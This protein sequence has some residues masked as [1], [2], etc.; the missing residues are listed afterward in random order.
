MS[1]RARSASFRTLRARSASFPSSSHARIA[2]IPSSSRTTRARF[3]QSAPVCVRDPLA[4]NR[5]RGDSSSPRGGMT[6]GEGDVNKGEAP[7]L[8]EL[9]R[10][11]RLKELLKYSHSFRLPPLRQTPPSTREALSPRGS[12][13]MTHRAQPATRCTNFSHTSCAFVRRLRGRGVDFFPTA[14]YNKDTLFLRRL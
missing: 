7:S 9:P 6:V 3:F 12:I 1:S 10:T 8:R 11:P 13:G 14:P 5:P 2:S 4:R